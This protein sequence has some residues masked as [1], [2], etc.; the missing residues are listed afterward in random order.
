[1]KIKYSFKTSDVQPLP[2][3]QSSNDRAFGVIHLVWQRFIPNK[4]EQHANQN[5]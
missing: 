2:M 1:M 4:P 5:G 3:L